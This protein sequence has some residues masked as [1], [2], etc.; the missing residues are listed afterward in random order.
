MTFDVVFGK[1]VH[2]ETFKSSLKVKVTN[3]LN[4]YRTDFHQICTDDRTMAVGERSEVVFPS[5]DV[6]VATNF[7]GKIDLQS[8]H[9]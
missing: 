8:T 1:L 5:R 6:A 3:Y 7:V 2:L 4:I 9:L